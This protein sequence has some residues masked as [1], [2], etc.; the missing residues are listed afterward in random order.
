MLRAYVNENHNNWDEL[1]D[2]AEIAYNNS[3]QAST[4]FTPHQLVYGAHAR[5]PLS[6][7]VPPRTN[8][9]SAEQFAQ[10]RE[11]QLAKAMRN[12]EAAQQKQALY[13]NKHRRDIKF[14][15]G[16]KVLLST[17]HLSTQHRSPKL[18]PRF[19]GPFPIVRVVGEVTYELSLP[20]KYARAA[21]NVSRL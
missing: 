11:A 3:V 18:L 4:G 1:L 15:V 6:F 10:Q 19:V 12:L 7:A 9:P 16:D 5:T 8:V 2:T 14:Q 17:E 20:A 21:P 13:A